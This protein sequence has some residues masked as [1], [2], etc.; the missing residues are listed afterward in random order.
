LNWAGKA[1]KIKLTI[2][3]YE[4]A[5]HFTI[6]NGG[7]LWFG[8]MSPPIINIPQSAILGMHQDTRRRPMAYQ[9]TGGVDPVR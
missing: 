3:E 1:K 2:E 7:H 6:T 4:R 5:E 8:L 9:W